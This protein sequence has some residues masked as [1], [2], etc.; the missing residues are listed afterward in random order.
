MIPDHTGLLE[1]GEVYIA[2]YDD[3]LEIEQSCTSILA[4]RFPAYIAEDM[5]TLK[6]ATRKTLRFRSSLQPYGDGL[7]DFFENV[8]NCLIISSKPLEGQCIAD[9]MSGGDYDGDRAWVCWDKALIQHVKPLPV[10]PRGDSNEEARQPAICN[11][12][13]SIN[14]RLQLV[15]YAHACKHHCTRIGTLSNRLDYKWD[16][17]GVESK[18]TQILAAKAFIQVCRTLKIRKQPILQ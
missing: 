5:L 15:S 11:A 4:M 3:I 10:K 17:F 1:A 18:E 16:R 6:V 2:L 9:L 14:D 13:A 12:E 8:R 7:Y